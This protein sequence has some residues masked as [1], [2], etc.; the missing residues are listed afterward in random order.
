L[1]GQRSLVIGAV[2]SVIAVIGAFLQPQVFFRGY[3]VSYMDWLGITLGSMAILMLRHLTGGGWGMVIRRILGAAMRCLPLMAVLFVPIIIGVPKL[4][5]WAQPLDTIADPKL[6]EHL[7]EITQTY[8]NR[9]GFVIRAIIY[10][11]IWGT[12]IFLL[13]KWSREQNQ[14]PVRDN[15]SKFKVIAGPGLILYG[16]AISFA[17][18]DWVM[19]L[20]P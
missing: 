14:P 9:S 4:Y 18:V 7:A 3:L 1:I 11:V 2:F 8:L 10:F 15:S 16:F 20:D 19:S 17:A 13:S 6:R 5:I 12:F